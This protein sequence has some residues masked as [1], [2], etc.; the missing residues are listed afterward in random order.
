MSMYL[1]HFG[2]TAAPFSTSPDP[3]FAYDTREHQLAVAKIAYSVEERRGIFLLTGEIG[4]GKTTISQLLLNSWEAQPEKFVV[5]HVTDPSASTPAA[6]LR[7]IL[8][9]F[10]QPTTRNLQDLKDALRTFLI[11]NHTGNK[12][13][14]LM[15]DEAQTISRANLDL[16]QTL[17]NEQTQKVKLIQMVLFAQPNFA[18]KLTQKPAL[19]SRITG[20]ANLNPLT[21]EDSLEMLRYRVAVAGGD[22]S[23]LFC[24]DTHK[25]LYNAGSGIPREMCVLS[26]AAL[27][28]AFA[29]RRNA[30]DMECLAAATDDLRFKGF[31]LHSMT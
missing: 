26:D 30:V 3:E 28:N 18:N 11:E 8:S 7:L 24:L 6:F 21:L 2:L 19:R 14:V 5:A 17:S 29:L 31:R 9:S 1:T 15:L 25:A 27:V 16:L 22:F 20:G 12:T 13:T 4:T 23:K 10:G